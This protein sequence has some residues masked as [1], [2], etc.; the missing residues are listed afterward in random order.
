[1]TNR[2]DSEREALSRAILDAT[3]DGLL[4]VD[5]SGKVIRSNAR[6][7]RMWRIPDDLLASQDDDALLAHVV[8][9]LVDPRSFLAKVE[10]LYASRKIDVDTLHFKDGRVFE[11]YSAPLLVADQLAGRVWSFRDLT[12]RFRSREA[13]AISEE[14]FRTLYNTAP[15]MMHSINADSRIVEVNNHWLESMGYTREQVI[16]R[17]ATTFVTEESRTILDTEVLPRFFREGRTDDF[18]VQMLRADGDILDVRLTARAEF[19]PDGSFHRSFTV[20]VDVTDRLRAEREKEQLQAQLQQAQKMESLGVLAGGIAHDFN[21]LLVSIMGNADLAL[22]RM[23]DGSPGRRNIDEVMKGSHRAADLCKQMLAYSGK[24]R[25]QP[26]ALNIAAIIEE[27]T[28][29]LE[30]SISKRARIVCDFAPDLPAVEADATQ[31]RQVV[32]NLITNASDAMEDNAGIINLATGTVHCDR[33]YLS[34]LL[35]NEELIPGDYVFLEVTDSGKGMDEHTRQRI[36]DPFF[37][38]KATGRGLGLAATLGIVRAHHG[39]IKV[40]SEPGHGTTFKVLLPAS[41]SRAEQADRVPPASRSRRLSGTALVV[42]DEP[43][44]RDLA[45]QV[46]E[47]AGLDVIEAA[48]GERAIEIVRERSPAISI[49]VL[50]MTMPGLDGE[51]TFRRLRTIR[52]DLRVVLSSGYNAQAAT[53]R[54]VGKGLAGFVH[55]PYRAADLIDAVADA[56]ASRH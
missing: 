37:T 39:T 2:S 44:V 56:L 41:R 8:D 40:Y 9:Q 46:L 43:A 17:T 42:D 47:H 32:M 38:T 16:G 6:F 1:M 18:P 3:A 12:E 26:R 31:L 20:L 7:A 55:K 4:V 53:S 10:Q 29:L 15:V 23:E 25:F 30:V 33:S 48:S 14:R 13:L 45:R 51:Q 34:R 24:G 21:N 52:G 11:R 50:D 5:A 27:M 54:F 49:V 36:F 28:H 22:M 35:V 19:A